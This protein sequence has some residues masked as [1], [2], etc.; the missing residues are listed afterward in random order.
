MKK[1][2]MNRYKQYLRGKIDNMYDTFDIK[3]KRGYFQDVT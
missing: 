3:C 2:K 1:K